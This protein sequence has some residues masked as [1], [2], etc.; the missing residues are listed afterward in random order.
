LGSF[1]A[2]TALAVSMICTMLV[3]LSGVPLVVAAVTLTLFVPCIAQ[4]MI[5]A[6]E[7]GWRTAIAM[8]LFIFPY[9]FFMGW[10][11]N[12]HLDEAWGASYEVRALWV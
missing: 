11:V 12:L 4:F 10:L 7:R 5:T 3:V 2:I 9:A 6:K 1:G 8:A